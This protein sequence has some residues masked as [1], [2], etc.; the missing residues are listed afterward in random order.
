MDAI[1]NVRALVSDDAT[2]VIRI[3][4]PAAEAVGIG[5]ML[6]GGALPLLPIEGAIELRGLRFAQA[7]IEPPTAYHAHVAE[8]AVRDNLA[9]LQV[10]VVTPALHADLDYALRFLLGI[11]QF[12]A[13]L[14]R[15]AE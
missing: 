2:C 10:E 13:L 3:Q 9:A 4:A 1:V 7:V 11:H 6:L 14:R 12:D 15:L 5:R 8:G